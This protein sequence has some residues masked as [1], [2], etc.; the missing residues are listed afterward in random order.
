MMINKPGVLVV[1]VKYGETNE[2]AIERVKK[3]HP[4]FK[5]EEHDLIFVMNFG[6]AKTPSVDEQIK[7]EERKIRELKRKAKKTA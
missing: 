5:A 1:I 7:K 4:N 2:H 3:E 6:S